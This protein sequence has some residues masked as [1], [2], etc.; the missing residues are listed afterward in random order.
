M[1]PTVYSTCTCCQQGTEF[2]DESQSQQNG[3]DEEK[4]LPE[5][6][7]CKKE[8]TPKRVK[9][10]KPKTPSPATTRD[11]QCG[12]DQDEAPKVC[13][14][15]CCSNCCLN[16]ALNIGGKGFEEKEGSL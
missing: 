11:D 13:S 2:E 14:N 16:I 6:R 8:A 3:T 10:E 12:H 4:P 5:E 7:C 9:K 1:T 15:S